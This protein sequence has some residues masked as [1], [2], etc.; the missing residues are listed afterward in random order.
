MEGNGSIEI[1]IGRLEG[2]FGAIEDKVEA[3]DKKLDR[4]LAWTSE[5]A[6]ALQESAR[7]ERR[8]ETSRRVRATLLASGVS[9]VS[10]VVS[11][12]VS[13]AASKFHWTLR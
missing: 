7:H 1:R 9:G 13:V 6:G 8:G 12:I 11:L 5:R 2:R 4:V 3:M 10:G